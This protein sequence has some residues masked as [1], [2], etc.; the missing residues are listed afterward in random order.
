[1]LIGAHVPT[2]GALEAAQELE[3]E[4]LQMFLGDPQSFKAPP[5]PPDAEGLKASGLPIYI[6]APYR[7]N[8]ASPN[9]RIRIPARKLLA[10]TLSRAEELG[11]AGVIVHGGH[12]EDGVERGFMRWR[13]VF[14]EATS[15][16]P[17]VLEN[18]AGGDNAMTRHVAA[19]AGLWA[20]LEEFEPHFCF[21]TCHAHAA[22]ENLADVVERTLQVTG[23]IDVVH[24]NNSRDDFGSGRDRHANFG[25]GR[26]HS[27]DIVAMTAQAG[28]PAV[29]CETA[30]PG[31]ADDLSLLRSW[32]GS[33]TQR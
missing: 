6:H 19:L 3:A 14:E 23:R 24:A 28:A 20:F 33:A 29:I 22:G 15:K 7:L 12:A 11:A 27:E 9:N 21:D 17:I 8:I 18:T 32:L 13:K 10:Q 2:E 26:I 5:L 16:V 4:C 31:I 1:M 25:D 30:W